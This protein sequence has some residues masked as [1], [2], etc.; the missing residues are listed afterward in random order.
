[1]AVRS[2]RTDAPNLPRE[3]QLATVRN[4]RA[5]IS[6]VKPFDTRDGRLHLVDLEYTDTEGTPTDSVIWEREVGARAHEP[7]ALPNVHDTGPMVPAGAFDALI[8]ASRW[9]ALTPFL[10]ADGSD[11]VAELP[12]ASP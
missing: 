3:G 8:R 6:R 7:G 11:G 9:S 12:V 5:I 4:R 2:A 10:P 1:M